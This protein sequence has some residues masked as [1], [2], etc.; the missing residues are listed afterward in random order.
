MNIKSFLLSL[1]VVVL[2]NGCVFNTA[3]EWAGPAYVFY[4]DYYDDNESQ[5]DNKNEI[6]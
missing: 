4:L 2:F 3:L 1:S 6:N 5:I